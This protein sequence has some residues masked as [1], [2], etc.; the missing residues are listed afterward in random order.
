MVAEVY[1]FIP[2]EEDIN[3]T[4]DDNTI[5]MVISCNLTTLS[6]VPKF[7]STKAKE[8]SIPLHAAMPNHLG[9]QLDK[10]ESRVKFMGNSKCILK[11]HE[12]PQKSKLKI[13]DLISRDPEFLLSAATMLFY[14]NKPEARYQS[15]LSFDL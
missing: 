3:D 5:S 14:S 6:K 11:T 10:T 12:L 4:T 13:R 8:T 2:N 1:L 7:E 15:V 9:Y